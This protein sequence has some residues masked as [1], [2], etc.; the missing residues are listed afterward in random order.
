MLEDLIPLGKAG[1]VGCRVPLRE[2]PLIYPSMVLSQ[3]ERYIGT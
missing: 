3:V 1:E 2:G